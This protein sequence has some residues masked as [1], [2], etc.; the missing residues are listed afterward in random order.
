M[1]VII[2]INEFGTK[3]NFHISGINE[4]NNETYYK[5]FGLGEKQSMNH[6]FDSLYLNAIKF[7]KKITLIK[8]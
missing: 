2:S 1:T 5:D 7:D 8:I 6:H 3:H 4:G